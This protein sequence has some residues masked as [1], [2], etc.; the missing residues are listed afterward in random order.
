MAIQTLAASNLCGQLGSSITMGT[1][2]SFAKDALSTVP[3]YSSGGSLYTFYPY[4]QPSAYTP[5]TF[6]T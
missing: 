4:W 1:T 3:A 5:A 6:G 2:L